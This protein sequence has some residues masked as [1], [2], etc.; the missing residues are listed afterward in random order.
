MTVAFFSITNITWAQPLASSLIPAE[1]PSVLMPRIDKISIPQELG[2]IEAKY[3]ASEEKPFIVVIQDAHAIIDAQTNIQGL[4]RFFQEKYGIRL[5]AFEGDKGKLDPTLLRSFP[6]EFIKKKILN[7]YLDQGELTGTEMAAILNPKAAE[8]HGIEDWKL[9]E[10]NYVAYLKTSQ[11]KEAILKKLGEIKG[12]LDQER[13]Q[14]YSVELNEFHEHVEAFQE[15][16]SHLLELLKY[17]TGLKSFTDSRSAIH[18][19][20]PHLAILLDSMAKDESLQKESLDV[21]IRSLAESFKKKYAARLDKKEFMEFNE[22][23]QSYVT[24]RMDPGSFLKFVVNL[25]HSKGL[26]PRL[27][28]LMQ[29]L[30]GNAETLSTIKGTKLFDELQIFLAAIEE[31]LITKSDERETSKKYQRIR[32]LKDLASLELSRDQLEQYEKAPQEYL[33]L[34]DKTKD[35]LSPAIEFYRIARERDNAFHRNLVS[36]LKKEKAKAAIVLAGGFHANGIEK[37]IKKEGYSYALIMPKINSL[38]GQ[39][40]YSEIMQGKLSYKQ[41][42]ETSFYDA[43][44]RASSVKLFNEFNEPDFKKNLKLW[45]DEVIRQL[46]NEGRITQASQYT[47]YIDLLL[48]AYH[49]RYGDSNKTPKTREQIL[50]AI[51]GELKQFG[52]ETANNLWQRFEPKFKEFTSGLRE[53]MERKEL[54]VENVS[55]LLDRAGK[56]KAFTLKP[57]VS[58]LALTSDFPKSE[59]RLL[60]NWYQKGELLPEIVSRSPA[61]SSL[62]ISNKAGYLAALD[63]LTGKTPTTSECYS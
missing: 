32:L 25:A 16:K 8:Y 5:I 57:A 27:T 17:L 23:Y 21:S 28:P 54:T 24:A 50:K 59:A 61:V 13:K 55:S 44:M 36:L 43:F 51:D 10:E 22:N 34:L 62:P 47:R 45:R 42:L 35:E 63:E 46:S 53:L 2:S 11:K 37:N 30:L 7:E 12:K 48:K 1:G 26:K 9:Y 3:Q 14:I 39:E 15:E 49:D 41:Y 31:K 40:V 56:A 19:T 58:G 18:E 4:I 60:I 20:Y 29:E 52:E 6:D 33:Q 38:T